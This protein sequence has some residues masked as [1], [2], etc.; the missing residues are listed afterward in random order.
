MTGHAH[1]DP[2]HSHDHGHSH[3][4]A[5]DDH[6]PGHNHV[7]GQGPTVLDIGDDFGALV[8]YTSA[9]LVGAEIEI[10]PDG[11]PGRRRHVAVHTREF[12]GGTAYAAV[13]YG[14][15][16]GTYDL[17]GADGSR[18]LTVSIEGNEITEAVWPQGVLAPR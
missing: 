6:L 3:G 14:L 15:E 16:A 5:H 2:A 4:H 17:W 11:H 10:S 9:D 1:S 13:Y 18:A 12:P 8:L 7:A